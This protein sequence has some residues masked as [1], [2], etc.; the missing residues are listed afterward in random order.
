MK[1]TNDP[2]PLRER[3]PTNL[4]SEWLCLPTV[5]VQEWEFSAWVLGDHLESNCPEIPNPHLIA[6][7]IACSY[8]HYKNRLSQ[9]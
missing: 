7:E 8:D 9:P 2:S 3:P 5:E 1:I 4:P 6:G